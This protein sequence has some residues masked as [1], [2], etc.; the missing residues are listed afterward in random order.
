M[1]YN[2]SEL[3]LFGI[4]F[5]PELWQFGIILQCTWDSIGDTVSDNLPFSFIPNFSLK[6]FN[7]FWLH[8][9]SCYSA[10]EMESETLAPRTVYF[11]FHYEKE[12]KNNC[13]S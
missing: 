7:L 6:G 8:N 4:F 9:K 2:K 1:K 5:P 13:Q 3:R 11:M 10:G 12:Q